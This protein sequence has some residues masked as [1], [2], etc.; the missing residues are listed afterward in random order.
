MTRALPDTL[1]LA[2]IV[3]APTSPFTGDAGLW[4]IAA[5][6]TR[7]AIEE[8][9]LIPGDQVTEFFTATEVMLQKAA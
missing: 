1:F 6:I 5:A 2:L 8:L 3:I 9:Q 7:Q 4:K